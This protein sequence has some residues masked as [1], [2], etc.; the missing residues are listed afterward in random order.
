MSADAVMQDKETKGC[1]CQLFLEKCK[2]CV[3]VFHQFVTHVFDTGDR[4]FLSLEDYLYSSNCCLTG[5]LL[6]EMTTA[7]M[8]AAN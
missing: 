8:S 3:S 1:T 6:Q 5:T 4:Q 7:W 2:V